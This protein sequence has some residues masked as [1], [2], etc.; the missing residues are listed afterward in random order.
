[1]TF[2]ALTPMLRCADLATALAFYTDTLAFR[3]DGGAVATGWV[4]LRHG[5][6]ALMLAAQH[7]EADTTAASTASSLYFRTDEV[8]AWWQRLQPH[9]RIVYPLQDFAYGMREF[10]L[11]DPDG[12]LLQ[13]GQA[14]CR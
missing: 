13:F 2:T 12:H 11:R 4:S 7:T 6:L 10:A 14:L 1:M 8:D 5:P 9:G 3:L